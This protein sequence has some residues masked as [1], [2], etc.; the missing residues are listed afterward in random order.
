MTQDFLRRNRWAVLVA[1]AVM[2]LCLPVFLISWNVRALA[3]WP[4]LYE[5]GF[6][7]KGVV[8][9]TGIERDELSDA[10]RQ[11]REYFN[12]DEETLDLRVQYDGETVSLYGPQEVAHMRDVK[13]LIRGVW[14]AGW[15]TGGLIAALAAAGVWLLGREALTLLKRS[16]AWSAYGSVGAILV[17]GVLSLISFRFVFTIFHEISFANDLWRLD[18]SSSMLLAMFPQGFWFDATMLLAAMTVLEFAAVYG[19]ARW[20][21]RRF[22]GVRERV[23]I[24]GNEVTETSA[25]QASR[26]RP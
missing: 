16:V 3:N 18:S 12:N 20:A 8:E 13:D 24:P 6:T 5:Y 14:A 9:R 7:E 17:I 10:G 25:A 2:A 21:A 19:A 26:S 15:V 1:M 23:S 4:T 11:I 22:G